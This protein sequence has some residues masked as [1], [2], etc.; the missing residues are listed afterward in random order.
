MDPN[1]LLSPTVP[2][3]SSR[4]PEATAGNGPEEENPGGERTRLLFSGVPAEPGG[5]EAPLAVALA[6][7]VRSANAIEQS[8]RE[9]YCK[10]HPPQEA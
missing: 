4:V 6:L 2:D 1:P 3:P 5:N 9:A 10:G 7:P 8:L